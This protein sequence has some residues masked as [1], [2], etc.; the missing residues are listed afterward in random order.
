MN[1]HD[2]FCN[3]IL[4]INLDNLNIN[5]EKMV[6]LWDISLDR[7]ISFCIK[8]V[9]I[10][11]ITQA[12]VSF[13]KYLF[14]RSQRRRRNKIAL[15]DQTTE[16]FIQRI[17][18]YAI[19][20]IGTGIFLSLIPG[21][22]KVSSSILAGAGIMAMAVGFAS[23]E[24]LSNF[25]SGLFI[26][27]GKPFRI[28][29]SIMIDSVVNG[30]VSEITLRHTVIKS[31]DNRMIIIP[32]SKINSSTIVNSTIGEQ[33][34]CSFIEVGVSYD[35]DLDKAINVMRDEIMHHPMLI[36]RR[37]PEEKQAGTPQVVIRVI[38][39]GESAITLK[40]WAW[41][42]NAGNAFV[43]KCDLLKSIKERFDKE[44]IEI[45]YPYN[46]VVLRQ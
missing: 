32:N 13:T 36:D 21:M 3:T 10:Y 28:G 8:A 14:R 26:V 29:D 23:Q 46:N 40:A 41:A 42:T 12:T 24:A 25:V 37:T 6:S 27:F 22:E 15:L 18:V 45:P 35:T 17:L 34:T 11:A 19:Y 30:T 1:V 20:I 44:N 7:V 33:D 43:L 5:L 39:L 4:S 16:S 9:L 38:N 31:L 2:F